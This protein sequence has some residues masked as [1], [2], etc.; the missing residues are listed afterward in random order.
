MTRIDNDITE[1]NGKNIVAIM[2]SAGE[3][4]LPTR[5]FADSRTVTDDIRS[6]LTAK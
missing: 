3:R 5:L 2:P 6:L 4:H 1:D